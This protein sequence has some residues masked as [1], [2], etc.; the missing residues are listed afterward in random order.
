[1][2]YVGLLCN[3]SMKR[4]PASQL[5]P[6]LIN[7]GFL[8]DRLLKSSGIGLFL[9]S[10]RRVAPPDHVPGYV[11]VD[12]ELVAVA[13]PV[14]RV[15]ANWT[16]GTR[17]LI[18][19]GMGYRE[20]KRWARQNEI[21]I[22]VPYSF[23]ELVSNKRKTYEVVKEFDADLHPHT[24]D[25]GA[26]SAQIE[27]FL[28]R[29]PVVFIK[30]RAGN[31]GN[32]IIVLREKS[33]G[34]FLKYYD[35]GGQRVFGPVTLETAAGIIDVAAS[36]RAYVIQEGIDSFRY[37]DSVFDIR[38][39]MVNDGVRWHSILETRLA[40]SGSDVSNV[41]Q[42]GSIH[43]TEDLL[44]ELFG[45]QGA[46]ET[47]LE[48]RRVSVSLA[49]YFEASYPSDLMEI[50]LDFILDLDKKLHLVEVNAKPGIAGFG[51]EKSLFEWNSEDDPDC[52]RWVHP[53]TRHLAGFLKRKVEGLGLSEI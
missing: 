38:V 5:S 20:F 50:G 22:Y 21:E 44:S 26:G 45:E 14:P 48:I 51:S 8:I 46:R 41:Y 13:R 43:V 18:N 9:Y 7:R 33:E 36:E 28:D 30:P 34:L 42:G 10:P 1:M 4:S 6:S 53:H 3:C 40:Q 23:S 31:R 37:N 19:R 2:K 25:Y 17:R 29:G 12:D 11:I 52:A 49:R 47:E 16:Y 15:N 32:R 35:Q 27:S 39:V 24:E